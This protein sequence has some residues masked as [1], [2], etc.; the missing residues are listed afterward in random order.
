MDSSGGKYK[1]IDVSKCIE[2]T[3][4]EIINNANAIIALMTVIATS[5]A[6]FHTW[7]KKRKKEEQDSY[8]L[9]YQHLEEI[10][11]ELILKIGKELKL[12]EELSEK[13]KILL[14]LQSRCPDCY[15]RVVKKFKI[16]QNESD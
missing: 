16:P 5:V 13:K 7:N 2:Y 8:T 10:K 9:L 15:D 6:G 4:N 11:K 14:E 1:I 3:M 12:T